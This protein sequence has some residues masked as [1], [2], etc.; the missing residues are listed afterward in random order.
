MLTVYKKKHSLLINLDSKISILIYMNFCTLDYYLILLMNIIYCLCLLSEEVAHIGVISYLINPSKIL[1]H[2]I[3]TYNSTLRI[4]LTNISVMFI[5]KETEFFLQFF[6]Y[7]TRNLHK[8]I[9]GI[10]NHR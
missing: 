1:S 7:G 10:R 6:S 3:T 2:K 8:V 9:A 5:R 4:K